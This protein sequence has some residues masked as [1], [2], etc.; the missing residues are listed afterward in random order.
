M[1]TQNIG[2]KE[3]VSLFQKMLLI[4]RFEEKVIEMFSYNK[5]VGSIHL[6]VGQED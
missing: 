3:K 4:R 1:S 5:V 6:S 2:E